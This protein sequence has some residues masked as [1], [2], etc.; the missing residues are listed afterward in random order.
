MKVFRFMCNEEFNKYMNGYT[1]TN[2]T[3]HVGKT[4][5]VGFCF[6]SLDDVSP[7]E[8]MHF[9]SGIV[10]FNVC[11]VFET[12]IPLTESYGIYAKPI[13]RTYDDSI[14]LLNLLLHYNEQFKQTEYCIDTYNKDTFKL[15][16]YSTDIWEQWNLPQNQKKLTWKG[17]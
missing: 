13:E 14:D 7:E 17:A 10:S 15:L 1:L 12:D 2:T 5:S 9:L 6:L 16:K 4:N 8:A 11:A 3:I